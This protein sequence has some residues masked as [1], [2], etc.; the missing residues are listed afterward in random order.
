MIYKNWC[1]FA[2]QSSD[3]KEVQ[4]YETRGEL[5]AGGDADM[6]RLRGVDAGGGFRFGFGGGFV[7]D[8]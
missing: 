8:I 1:R 6:L 7:C 3:L 2:G 4:E 5:F